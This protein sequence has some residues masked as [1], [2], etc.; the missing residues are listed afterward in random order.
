[1]KTRT[2]SRF[3]RRAA[4]LGAFVV[5]SVLAAVACGGRVDEEVDCA[6]GTS[7]TTTPT[8][9]T[10]PYGGPSDGGMTSTNDAGA[11]TGNDAG[12]PTGNDAGT[13]MGSDAGTAG[14]A[15]APVTGQSLSTGPADFCVVAPWNDTPQQFVSSTGA[16]TIPAGSYT[17]RY[18]GGAQNHDEYQQYGGNFE[19]SANYM[20]NGLEAGHHLYD[21]ASPETSV[22]SIWLDATGLIGDLPD[23]ATVQIDNA[24]HTWPV[25]LAGGPL[26]VTYYDNEY[27]DNIGPGTQLCIDTAPPSCEAPLTSTVQIT[28][29]VPWTDTGIDVAAGS[30]LAVTA[31]GTVTYG[32][33]DDSIADANGGNFDGTTLFP[34]DVYP[35]TMTQRVDR[36][37]LRHDRRR[38][39]YAAPGRGAAARRGLRRHDVLTDDARERTNLPRVQRSG[40]R[41]Q[42]QLGRVHRDDHD[43]AACDVYGGPAQQ[44]A[45]PAGAANERISLPPAEQTLEI[46]PLHV[47]KIL[48]AARARVRLDVPL[49]EHR[50][51]HHRGGV[52]AARA[53]ERDRRDRFVFGHEPE[54]SPKLLGGVRVVR[55]A[56]HDAP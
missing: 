2:G 25:T 40:R 8:A 31:T 14:D 1:M 5:V 39:R 53:R 6:P 47:R 52:D 55:C 3:A 42:R 15:G 43:H 34:G 17:L 27:D 9:P 44:V 30:T 23:V 49:R 35:N 24:G 7:A 22:T 37:N 41:V 18:V 20:I 56:S 26:F 21:G 50:R 4:T 16:T 54:P 19:V 45:N 48:R 36:K 51:Q 12:A 38:H 11:P 29:T 46:L 28:S 13:P 33:T 32:P 10:M